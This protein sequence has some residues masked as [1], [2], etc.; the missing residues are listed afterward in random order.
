MRL[1]CLA[2]SMA[3]EERTSA[4]CF[5]A[6]VQDTV[7]QEILGHKP[8]FE[9][10]I[11]GL[12][13]PTDGRRPVFVP[14]PPRLGTD[15]IRSPYDLDASWWTT[16]S[17][18]SVASALDEATC[19][20]TVHH[21]PFDD[22]RPLKRSYTIFCTRQELSEDR[23]AIP[24]QPVNR[25]INWLM[26]FGR[27]NWRGNILVCRSDTHFGGRSKFLMGVSDMTERDLYF[28]DA[29]IRNLIQEKLLGKERVPYFAV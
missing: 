21:Y 26:Q 23:S 20:I 12:L 1:S 3:N 7:T 16:W 24:V 2:A 4:P 15:G 27:R 25:Q 11:V 28:A 29:I 9:R 17:P 14:V 18:C 13:Y 8:P 10:T 6:T 22:L 19:S 5:T